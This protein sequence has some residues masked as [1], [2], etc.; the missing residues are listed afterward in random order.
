ML[1]NFIDKNELPTILKTMK[2]FFNFA[3]VKKSKNFTI[4]PQS[5]QAVEGK[6]I[7]GL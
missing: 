4:I 2:K 6:D 7:L 1:M 3:D 5:G